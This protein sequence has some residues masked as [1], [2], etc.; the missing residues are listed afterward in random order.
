MNL[1]RSHVFCSLAALSA[2]HILVCVVGMVHGYYGPVLYQL[3]FVFHLWL[4]H[5]ADVVAN[6]LIRRVA[7]ADVHLIV[8][9]DVHQAKA[10]A[11]TYN[12]PTYRYVATESDLCGLPEGTTVYLQVKGH[13]QGHPNRRLYLVLRTLAAQRRVNII[14]VVEE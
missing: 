5:N 7:M 3:V 10:L 8:A 13:G 6:K 4:A 11:R 2:V 14:P 12:I 9:H 1:H